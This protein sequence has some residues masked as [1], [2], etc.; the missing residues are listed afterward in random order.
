MKKVVKALAPKWSLKTQ[1]IGTSTQGPVYRSWGRSAG[2]N[3]YKR[4][5]EHDRWWTVTGV[6][7]AKAGVPVIKTGVPVAATV[8]TKTS[9]PVCRSPQRSHL[10]QLDRYAGERDRSAGLSPILIEND[11]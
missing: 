9:G 7:V 5:F 2:L 6:P 3:G 10:V 8:Y 4:L 11:F 1:F